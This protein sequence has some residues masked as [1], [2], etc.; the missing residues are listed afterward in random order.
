MEFTIERLF[1][2]ILQFLYFLSSSNLGEWKLYKALLICGVILCVVIT[3]IKVDK[4][5]F[6]IKKF[7]VFLSIIALSVFGILFSKGKEFALLFMYF[8]GIMGIEKDDLIESFLIA[9]LMY[10]IFSFL[11]CILGFL[12]FTIVDEGKSILVLG[13]QNKNF[14]GLLIFDIVTLITIRS[15]EYD[16][17]KTVLQ[18]VS[19]ILCLFFIECRSAGYALISLLIIYP[20]FINRKSFE[21]KLEYIGLQLEYLILGIISLIVAFIF[22]RLPVLKGIDKLLSGRL[23]AWSFYAFNMPIRLFG[24]YFYTASLM[25]LDNG[26]L[27]IIFRYGF[28]LFL[29]ICAMS[30]IIVRKIYKRQDY[31]LLL[32]FICYSI[33][34]LFEFSP[35]TI[36]NNICFAYLAVDVGIFEESENY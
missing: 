31:I 17:R 30:L 3:V 1:I 22:P 2:I 26:Y 8:I 7:L 21:N 25:P 11:L 28:L 14:L 32:P 27:T 5:E 10:F 20:I 24:N 33:Y 15:E 18:L 36:F 12:N 29:M 9:D 6:E 4:K 19:M 16:V 35:M 23:S 13:F 34:S